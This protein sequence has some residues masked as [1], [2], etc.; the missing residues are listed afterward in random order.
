MPP[1]LLTY[2]EMI[3]RSFFPMGQ[4]L[5]WNLKESTGIFMHISLRL[6]GAKWCAWI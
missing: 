5:S 6:R 3:M 2:G 1:G 4:A